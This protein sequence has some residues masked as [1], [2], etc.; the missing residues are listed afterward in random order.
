ML[1]RDLS[2]LK[3]LVVDD[4]SSLRTLLRVLLRTIGVSNVLEASD[5]KAALELLEA[6][7]VDLVITDMVMKPMDGIEFTRRLRVP[8]GMNS[9]VPVL[10]ISGHTEEKLAKNALQA[11]V[12]QFLAKPLTTVALGA[13]LKAIVEQ[14]ARFAQSVSYC[15]PDRRS[16]SASV[17]KLRRESD[18]I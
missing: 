10:M 18:T 6:Q 8:E 14:P 15:E 13:R 4:I 2:C 3:V 11:G 1:E 7:R 9:Y 12:T 17:E 16:N 5:G